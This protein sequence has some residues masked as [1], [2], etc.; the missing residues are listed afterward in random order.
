MTSW[1]RKHLRSVST[2]LV[3]AFAGLWLASTC[4][5]VSLPCAVPCH[6]DAAHEMAMPCEQ[7]TAACEL[8][9]LTAAVAGAFDFSVTPVLLTSIPFE[10]ATETVVRAPPVDWRATRP[11]AVP[12]YLT[13]LA[14]LN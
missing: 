14:L 1:S 2:A 10:F 4:A 6:G 9:S 8:P 7:M 13:H 5:A 3:A 12:L 11:P